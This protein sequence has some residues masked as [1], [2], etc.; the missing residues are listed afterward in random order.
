[1]SIFLSPVP[2][3]SLAALCLF[4]L[5]TWNHASAAQSSKS[6]QPETL[7]ASDPLPFLEEIITGGLSTR[8]RST[9]EELF[10]G[11]A[12]NHQGLEL[13]EFCGKASG[14][15]SMALLR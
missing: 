3:N 9:G 10:T 2:G 4:M 8:V 5:C 15:H 14:D 6:T 12:L 1:M 13:T 11:T 7:I